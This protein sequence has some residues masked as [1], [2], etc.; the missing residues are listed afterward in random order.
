MSKKI[1]K[2]HRRRRR[3]MKIDMENFKREWLL[4]GFQDASLVAIYEIFT[5]RYDLKMLNINF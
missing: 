1:S 5:H 3:V 2:G 4:F